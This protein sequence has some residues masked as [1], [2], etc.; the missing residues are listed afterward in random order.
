MRKR[1]TLTIGIENGFYV[2]GPERR[3][4][5]ITANNAP[6]IAIKVMEQLNPSITFVVE[7]AIT[8]HIKRNREAFAAAH[9][10]A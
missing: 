3:S 8:A 10:S 5:N 2:Y 4:T 7:P 1:E 6:G 9:A